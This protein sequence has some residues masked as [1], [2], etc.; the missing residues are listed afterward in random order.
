ML[1][2]PFVFEFMGLTHSSGLRWWRSAEWVGLG[3]PGPHRQPPRFDPEK[4]HQRN[5]VERGINTV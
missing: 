4:Y 3:A 2:V 1:V 5:V